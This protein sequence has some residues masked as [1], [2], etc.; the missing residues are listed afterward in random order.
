MLGGVGI[1]GEKRHC[2]GYNL[3]IKNIFHRYL[4]TKYKINDWY[5]LKTG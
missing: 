4:Y 1:G 2:T 5:D 3:W